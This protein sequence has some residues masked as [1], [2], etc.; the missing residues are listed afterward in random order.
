M[1]RIFAKTGSRD[2]AQ[3]MCWLYIHGY[4]GHRRPDIAQEWNRIAN[5]NVAIHNFIMPAL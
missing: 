4:T 3:A 5:G 2:R 1:R